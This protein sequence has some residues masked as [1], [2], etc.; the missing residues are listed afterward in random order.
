MS[1]RPEYSETEIHERFMAE[2]H[3][4]NQGPPSHALTTAEA[5][6]AQARVT[7]A[8]WD[9]GSLPNDMSLLAICEARV[10][11]LQRLFDSSDEMLAA[12]KD[13]ARRLRGVGMLSDD[14]EI[15]QAIALAEGRTDTSRAGIGRPVPK[16]GSGP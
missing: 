2:A 13:A 10:A 4:L 12:L 14:D 9:I 1:A 5:E 15:L 8:A 16:H 7:L 6:I 11:D 3:R